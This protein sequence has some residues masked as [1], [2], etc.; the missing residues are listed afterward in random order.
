MLFDGVPKPVDGKLFPD[1]S[2]PG[3]GI[4]FKYK[5]AEKYKV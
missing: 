3:L 2:R 4:E 5:E 1:M